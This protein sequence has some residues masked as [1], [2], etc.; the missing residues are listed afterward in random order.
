M[1]CMKCGVEI[2]EQQ[3]FCDHCLQIME[4]YPVKPDA[5]IHLP[6]RDTIADSAKRTPKKK[7]TPSA[8][9]KISTLQAKVVRLRL[10]AVVLLL[11]LCIVSALYGLRIYGDITAQPVTGQNYTID[12]SAKTPTGATKGK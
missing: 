10:I 7:R 5:H 8:E 2:P 12:T 9:E 4:Q 11:L 3:V 1:N 6:K